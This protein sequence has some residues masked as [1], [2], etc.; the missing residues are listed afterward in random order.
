MQKREKLLAD[1]DDVT[2]FQ[3]RMIERAATEYPVKWK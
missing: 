1:S 2:A 3:L